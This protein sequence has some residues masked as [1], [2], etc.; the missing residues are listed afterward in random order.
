M[1]EME[2][3]ELKATRE[4]YNKKRE[5]KTITKL[6]DGLERSEYVYNI[7]GDDRKLVRKTLKLYQNIKKEIEIYETNT[8]MLTE[9]QYWVKE[10]YHLQRLKNLMEGVEPKSI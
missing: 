10:K 5:G 6:Y 2:E 3:D 8:D 9:P 1:S 4:Y 7:Y